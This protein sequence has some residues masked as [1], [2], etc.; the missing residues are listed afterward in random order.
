MAADG[1]YNK[2]SFPPVIFTFSR[3]IILLLMPL[4]QFSAITLQSEI[5]LQN[6]QPTKLG[7]SGQ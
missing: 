5:R 1:E 2:I 4:T 3:E 7:R 6:M